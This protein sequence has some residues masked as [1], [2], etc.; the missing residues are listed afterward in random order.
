MNPAFTYQGRLYDNGSAVSGSYN[1]RFTL[2]SGANQ[3][4]TGCENP[5]MLP[6]ISIVNG[7]F[8]V[9]LPFCAAAFDGSDRWLQIE[10]LQPNGNGASLFS[11]T[12][13]INATPYAIHADTARFA[14]TAT[15]AETADAA[16]VATR[17]L[18]LDAAA[19]VPWS[20]ISDPPV[21]GSSY[22]A[23]AG[24]AL[25]GSTFSL[26]A[27]YV[28]VRYEGRF[29]KLGGNASVPGG[30]N[31]FGIVNNLPLDF[32]ANSQRILRLEPNSTSPNLIG[33]N[34]ANAVTS[35][36]V[37][38]T[39]GGGGTYLAPYVDQ[40]NRVTDDYGTVSGGLLNRAGNNSGVTSDASYATVSG[41]RNNTA[42][43]IAST[44][45]GGDGNAAAGNY[46]FAAGHN[47]RANH[48]GSF[49]WADS[50]AT[51]YL[52]TANDQFSV[53]AGGG[54][55]LDGDT[56]V[57]GLFSM[58]GDVALN[59]NVYALDHDLRLRSY[60]DINHGVGFRATLSSLPGVTLDGPF[61][62]GNLGGALGT[63][64]GDAVAL[65]WNSDGDVTISHN[66]STATLT[67]RGGADLAEP[68]NMSST[69]IPAGA[70]VVIDEAN[71]GRLKMS[72][73][74]YDKQVAGIVSGANGVNPGISLHQE[75]ALEGGQNVALTGRV[76]VQA[77][78]SSGSIKPGDLLTTSDTPGHAMKVGDHA[79]AQGAILGKAMTGLKS[80]QG[81]VLVLVSLQ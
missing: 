25:S 64:A 72:R 18:S 48:A 79:K 62:Y 61:L 31:V 37:G 21:L 29:W 57:N 22:S 8:S 71:P 12:Q 17:A 14:D 39:I 59:G 2:L 38:A 1:M 46:S 66:L 65:R 54:V 15:L 49:V 53:R 23:G 52:S 35:G 10:V 32:I 33:G 70:V 11:T 36:A 51:T 16:D 4:V 69:D 75:G 26:D 55:R 28:D 3:L 41:G 81:F 67:I 47:A 30:M 20:S 5:L 60:G 63:R 24:L 76:Y 68:F 43:G 73:S 27:D 13:K 78:A 45:A 56:T 44:V 77:D 7:V 80:G 50:T 42:S 9:S 19:R 58:N 34:S 40:R 6:N 74:A